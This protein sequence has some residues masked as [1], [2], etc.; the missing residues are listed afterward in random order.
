MNESGE[1]AQN[2]S[3]KMLLNIVFFDAVYHCCCQV[4]GAIADSGQ[5]LCKT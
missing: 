2:N 5:M 3:K 4:A 1:G